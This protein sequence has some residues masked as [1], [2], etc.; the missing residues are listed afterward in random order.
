MGTP[1]K[2]D[3]SGDSEDLQALFD[4]IASSAAPTVPTPQSSSSADSDEL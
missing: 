4:S 3:E 1:A 2:F